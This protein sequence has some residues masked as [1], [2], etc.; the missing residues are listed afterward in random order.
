MREHPQLLLVR[1]NQHLNQINLKRH[2]YV[3][4]S[5]ASSGVGR[6]ALGTGR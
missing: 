1:A 5:A 2:R 3:E 6:R 4:S